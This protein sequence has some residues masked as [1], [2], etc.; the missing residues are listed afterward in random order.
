MERYRADITKEEINQLDVQSYEGRITIIEES[1]FIPECIGEIRKHKIIG[2][3]TESRPS[4]NKKNNYKVSLIQ[5]AVQKEVYLFRIQKVGFHEDIIDLFEDP[6]I[7]KVGVSIH[8]DISRLRLLSHFNPQN[9]LELQELTN[10]YGIECNSLRKLV[11]IIL[12]FRISKSQQLSNWEADRL[13]EAQMVYAATD[14]WASLEIYKSLL[15][16]ESGL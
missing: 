13:T 1:R 14:A 4:F 2:F 10:E 9:F 16:G 15:N 3:D 8:D 6:S 12:G 5:L 11:A 7:K